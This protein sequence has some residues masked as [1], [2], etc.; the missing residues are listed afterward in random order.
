MQR[1]GRVYAFGEYRLDAGRRVLSRSGSAL[2]LSS[3]AIDTLLHLIEHAGETVSKA[4]LMSAVWPHVTVT[5]NSL[6]QAISSIRSALGDD[7]RGPAFVAT[8]PGRGYRFIANVVAE[9]ERSHD[10]VAYQHYVAGWSKVTR[11]SRTALDEAKRHFDKALAI[12]PTFAAAWLGLTECCHMYS[13]YSFLRNEDNLPV[14]L[15][16][17]KR[18]LAIDP[19]LVEARVGIARME[20]LLTLNL[21]R[22]EAIYRDIIAETPRCYSAHRYLGAQMMH[23]QRL[24]EAMH[25]FRRAQSV[26]PLSVTINAEVGMAHYFSDRYSH[27]IEQLELTLTMDPLFEIAHAFLGRCYLALENYDRASA[28][29]E[30]A[31]TSVYGAPSGIPIVWAMTGRTADARRA[32]ARMTHPAS[33]EWFRAH[34]IAQI[35]GALGDDDGARA[36]L[37]HSFDSHPFFAVDPLLRHLHGSPRF[38]CLVQRLNTGK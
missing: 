34:D 1:P 13:A 33:N 21:P 25:H 15:E 3:G 14:G 9:D 12:E 16:A 28:E 38:N 35:C 17:A 29:F 30:K 19:N 6:N 32:I 37:E 20:E 18:A 5:E 23:R 26:E 31:P 8:I 10:P 11:P 2:S 24:D 36:W 22:A 4:E 27:A 7:R